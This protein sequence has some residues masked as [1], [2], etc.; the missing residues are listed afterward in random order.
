MRKLLP[1]LLMFACLCLLAWRDPGTGGGGH[2]STPTPTSVPRVVVQAV[3]QVR[4]TQP[5]VVLEDAPLS[6]CPAGYKP[7]HIWYE[8][9]DEQWWGDRFWS[10]PTC[11]LKCVSLTCNQ[12]GSMGGASNCHVA[13]VNSWGKSRPPW[14][15][16]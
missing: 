13:Y 16:L 14:C 1:V 12:A 4:A 15:N 3:P 8:K 9:Y 11:I 7:E 6:D 5:P 10:G 2:G